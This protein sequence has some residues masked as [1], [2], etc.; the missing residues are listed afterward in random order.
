MTG[1]WSLA[2]GRLSA[3]AAALA[4]LVALSP[5]GAQTQAEMNAQA[6]TSYKT[7]DAAMTRQWQRS[8]AAMKRRD[9]ADTSRGGGFGYAAAT[10]ASQRAWLAF[11]DRQCVIEGGEFA[12]G[13][14]GAMTR[15][16]CM[17]RLTKER[18]VQ[19]K[20]LMWQR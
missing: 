13:S 9:A 8:Y 19:L 17:A 15:L 1:T 20:G 4:L 10:L 2:R 11:R 18:T 7:A 6:A 16:Q 3:G 12:G 5:A 14:L